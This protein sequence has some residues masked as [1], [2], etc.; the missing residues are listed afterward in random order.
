MSFAS[1]YDQVE[2][3]ELLLKHGADVNATNNVS[4]HSTVLYSSL[5]I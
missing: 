4:K 1:Y 2:I 3:V 5:F